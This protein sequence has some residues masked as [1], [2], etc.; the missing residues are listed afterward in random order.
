MYVTCLVSYIHALLFSSFRLFPLLLFSLSVEAS[1]PV[2]SGVSAI[3]LASVGYR[4]LFSGRP[5]RDDKHSHLSGLG[6]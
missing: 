5:S 1:G 6:T 4:N 3:L 2:S